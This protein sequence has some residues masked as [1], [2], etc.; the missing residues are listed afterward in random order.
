M[1]I[2]IIINITT[3]SPSSFFFSSCFICFS[4]FSSS[5]QVPVASGLTRLWWTGEETKYYLQQ[6]CIEQCGVWWYGNT[7]LKGHFPLSL[8]PRW[9]LMTVSRVRKYVEN[10]VLSCSKGKPCLLPCLLHNTVHRFWQSKSLSLKHFLRWIHFLPV[11]LQKDVSIGEKSEKNNQDDPN[12]GEGTY[13]ILV[14]QMK[15]WEPIRDC[16]N[17][18]T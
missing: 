4:A 13:G 12:P 11:K 14:W 7:P 1:I 3:L 18:M 5:H 2:N 6:C 17:K 10:T 9:L 16:K 8:Q 15:G